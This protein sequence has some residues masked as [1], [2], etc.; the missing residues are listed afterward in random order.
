[1]PVDH[2]YTRTYTETGA[3]CEYCDFVGP[4]GVVVSHEDLVHLQNVTRTVNGHLFRYFAS[5]EEMNKF[6]SLRR[7]SFMEFPKKFTPGW[8]NIDPLYD[9]ATLGWP[10]L[11]VETMISNLR[12]SIEGLTTQLTAYEE[13]VKLCP[14]MVPAQTEQ[15]AGEEKL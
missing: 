3:K 15:N 8:Y 2:T 6:R 10:V 14:G 7:A 9:M 13:L 11:N 5:V 12:K 4:Y 1:M